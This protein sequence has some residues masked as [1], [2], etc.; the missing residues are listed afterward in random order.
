MEKKYLMLLP[1]AVPLFLGGKAAVDAIK[2]RKISHKGNGD[3]ESTI[4][5]RSDSSDTDVMESD[6]H[7][8]SLRSATEVTETKEEKASSVDI[9]NMDAE[10]PQ[11][12]EIPSEKRGTPQGAKDNATTLDENLEERTIL[13]GPKGGKY[14]LNDKG[15]KIYLK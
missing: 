13:T 14:Y 15:K 4:S 9:V 2:R 11:E 5:L 7:I 6:T 3:P 12:E 8:D 1:L 10:L